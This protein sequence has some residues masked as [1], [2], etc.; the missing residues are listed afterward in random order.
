M[1]PGKGREVAGQSGDA[2]IR[3]D[4]AR[5]CRY[6]FWNVIFPMFTIASMFLGCKPVATSEAQTMLHACCKYAAKAFDSSDFFFGVE[7]SDSQSW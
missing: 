3:G 6:Y 2:T 7:G 1:T 4:G 5:S